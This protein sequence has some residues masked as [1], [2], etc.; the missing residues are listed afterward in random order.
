MNLSSIYHISTDNYCFPLNNNELVIRIQ[1]GYDIEK[2]ELMYGDPFISGIF[3]G[4]DSWSGEITELTNKMNLQNHIIWQAVVKPPFKRCRYYFI[5]HGNNEIYYF[6]EDGF[7]KEADFKAYKGRRQD[8]F[9]PWMNSSD[10]IKPA[11]WVNDTIWYQIFLDRFC[12]SGTKRYRTYD[13]WAGYN[14]KV[15]ALDRY[16]GDLKGVIDKLDYLKNLGING[17][18]F[19]PI[20]K[21]N[22]NH[23]YNIDD[24]TQIDPDFGTEEDLITLVEEA[25]KRDIRVMLDGVFNHC[26]EGFKPWL[27]VLKNGKNSKYFDWFMI[28]QLPETVNRFTHNAK[29]G[30]YYTFGFFDNMPKLNT[31]NQDVIDYFIAICTKW[32]KKYNIDAIR[33]D[34]ANEV[35]HNFSK[36]LRQ[37]MLKLKPDF[38]ICG[39]IWHNSIAWLRGDEYDAVMNYTLQES[40]DCF[41]ANKTITA[42]D[43]EYQINRCLTLYPEQV[44]NVMFNLLDSH[45]TMRLI[46]RSDNNLDI[47][48]QKLT[49]LFTLNGTACIYYGTEVALPGGFDP[50]CRRCM[51][52]NEIN[53]GKYNDRIT[54]IKQLISIR[55]QYDELRNGQIRFLHST[56][57]RVLLYE[58]YSDKNTIRIIAN[59]SDCNF[60]L[61]SSY[62]EIIFQIGFKNNLLQPNGSV[63][64][65]L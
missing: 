55:K 65:L 40:I 51:P 53:K 64:L 3:G 48:Y 50:D 52:W 13:N 23:K 12:N 29:N 46:T 41:W 58:K 60:T 6:T 27:D 44:N 15:G 2:V 43:F 28:N 18:Y 30:K 47:F 59:C 39:E 19:T 5:L 11:K 38:Y 31:N 26:G 14:K 35:S 1:T 54:A 49:V 20:N 61:E 4:N 7:R 56:N 57:N 32:V 62:K 25:H 16:G 22:S 36:Q 17:I 45:D 24:Y 33:L 10:I 63:V 21:S 37:A 8:F 9:F 34:V 42:L